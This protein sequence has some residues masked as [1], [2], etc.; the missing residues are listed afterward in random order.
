MTSFPL[1]IAGGDLV[2]LGD[3]ARLHPFASNV[4]AVAERGIARSE[5]WRADDAAIGAKRQMTIPGSRS[6][7]APD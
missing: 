2:S 6:Y 1:S 7:V 4:V 5:A 3:I